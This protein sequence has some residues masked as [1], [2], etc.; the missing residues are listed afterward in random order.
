MVVLPLLHLSTRHTLPPSDSLSR[1]QPPFP[2][3]T[4]NGL[5]VV[6]LMQAITQQPQYLTKQQRA[7][8]EVL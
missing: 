5:T 8:V 1:V 6:E 4:E 3:G 2:E 7:Q